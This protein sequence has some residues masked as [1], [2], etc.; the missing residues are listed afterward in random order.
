M[1]STISSIF[2]EKFLVN[3]KI[4]NLPI[5]LADM[6]LVDYVL[7][8][9]KSNNDCGRE[10][11]EKACEDFDIP[12]SPE[13]TRHD[14]EVD[15]DRVLICS[16]RYRSPVYCESVAQLKSTDDRDSLGNF[17]ALSPILKEG[18]DLTT[19]D[20][21]QHCD[22]G[23]TLNLFGSPDG[24]GLNY[25]PL[26]SNLN[27]RN[28]K[29]KISL[30]QSRSPSFYDENI[31]V[32]DPFHVHMF[33][34]L[35]L[36]PSYSVRRKNKEKAYMPDC[37][38]GKNKKSETLQ[39]KIAKMKQTTVTF[40][41][42]SDDEINEN[43]SDF[44]LSEESVQILSTASRLECKQQCR[45]GNVR[46][47]LGFKTKTKMKTKM[48]IKMEMKMKMKMKSADMRNLSMSPSSSSRSAHSSCESISLPPTTITPTSTSTSINHNLQRWMTNVSIITYFSFSLYDCCTSK[49]KRSEK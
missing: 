28:C 17:C 37:K 33:Y 7:A 14:A 44:N 25:G 1:R 35:S 36:S 15:D 45:Y 12:E 46:N 23:T 41:Y 18:F 42:D 8:F 43:N 31:V 40:Y 3:F 30:N 24:C 16:Q 39:K 27:T 34:K 21:D 32:N 22:L 48:E 5:S 11:S 4:D 2:D 9:D 47:A 19:F 13:A 26:L 6:L 49:M 38:T 10:V 20:H 29:K